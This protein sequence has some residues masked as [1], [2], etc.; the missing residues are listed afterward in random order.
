MAVVSYVGLTDYAARSAT[1]VNT[2]FSA[3]ATQSTNINGINFRDEGL[4]E[5]SV[6]AGVATDGFCYVESVTRPGVPVT[7]AAYATLTLDSAIELTNTGA[8]WAIGPGVGAVRVRFSTEWSTLVFVA[9]RSQTLY[10][11]MVYQIDGGAI[12]D[13]AKSVRAF[14]TNDIV[15][16][17]SLAVPYAVTASRDNFKYTML[18]SSPDGAAHTLNL[19]RMEVFT[20]NVLF[21]IGATTMTAMRLVKAV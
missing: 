15:G 12:T 17:N 19:V 14:W 4:D 10:F 16:H 9:N 8:G 18:I 2:M 13:V 3:F 20:N 7:T 1:T 5:G 21:T 11:H 6:S